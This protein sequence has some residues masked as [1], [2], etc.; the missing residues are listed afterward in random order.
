MSER[1]SHS[2][3]SSLSSLRRYMR[4]SA[5]RTCLATCV[6]LI[7]ATL[8][9]VACAKSEG[10][11]GFNDQDASTP[12]DATAPPDLAAA[13]PTTGAP[14][15]GPVEGGANGNHYPTH[16][17]PPAHGPVTPGTDPSTPG[18]LFG[19]AQVDPSMKVPS[20]AYPTPEKM[21]PPNMPA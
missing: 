16:P 5:P 14:S 8:L 9:A 18:G 20:L 1:T 11:P 13:V 12:L 7:S 4:R 6:T 21:F 15:L 3:A 2:P 19:G 17:D 10:A